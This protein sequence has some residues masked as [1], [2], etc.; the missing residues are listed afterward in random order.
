MEPSVLN[1]PQIARTVETLV[2][3]DGGRVTYD[4]GCGG[5]EML[6]AAAAQLAAENDAPLTIVEGRVLHGETRAFVRELQPDIHCAVISA[7]E[8]ALLPAGSITGVLRD[9]HVRRPLL[10]MAHSASHLVVPDTTTATPP[11]T[12]WPPPVSSCGPAT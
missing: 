3:A 10:A 5:R 11:S 7:D 1:H 2:A 6:V 9:P 4:T 12:P 8:A